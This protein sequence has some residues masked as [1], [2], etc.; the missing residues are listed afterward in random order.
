MVDGPIDTDPAVLAKVAM[1]LVDA[2]SLDAVA[3]AL[4]RG[5]LA[6]TST[7]VRHGAVAAGSQLVEAGLRDL[8]GWWQRHSGLPPEALALALRCAA[9]ALRVERGHM[10]RTE[11]VWTGPRAETSYLRATRQVVLELIRAARSEILVVGY[12][13]APGRRSTGVVR[14]IVEA[15]SEAMR[16]GA[17]VTVVLD[18]TARPGG[19]SNREL[20]LELWPRDLACPSML[21][22]R[23]PGDDEHLKLHAKVIVVDRMDAL[24]TSANLTMHAMDLNMEMGVRV[25]GPPASAI[26]AHFE[27]L[28]A[29]GTLQPHEAAS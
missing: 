21:T 2:G 15:I 10:A 6:P 19:G 20:F 14:Q 25:A 17:R 1:A 22:W 5:G 4:L 29:E 28:I 18:H 11:V 26:A 7:S 9:E 27:R 8:Q 13:I 24:V 16:R 23:A 12:W 3:R